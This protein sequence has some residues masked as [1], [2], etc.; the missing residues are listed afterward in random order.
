MVLAVILFPWKE[1]LYIS[2]QPH[3]LTR[4]D[5]SKAR[6]LAA[7][8]HKKKSAGWSWHRSKVSHLGGTIGFDTDFMS[9]EQLLLLRSICYCILFS[10]LIGVH[11]SE[12]TSF[13]FLI[14]KNSFH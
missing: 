7:K 11:T 10:G 3:A 9:A 5:D 12:R 6:R 14:I 4:R 8:E 2:A 13:A 1:I